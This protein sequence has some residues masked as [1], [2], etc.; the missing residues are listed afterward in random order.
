MLGDLVVVVCKI[1]TYDVVILAARMVVLVDLVGVDSFKYE[2][3]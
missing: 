1:K 3:K 2:N